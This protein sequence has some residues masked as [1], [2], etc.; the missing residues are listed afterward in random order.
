MQGLYHTVIHIFNTCMMYISCHS[1]TVLTSND[2]HVS[3]KLEPL[4]CSTVTKLFVW[5]TSSM[6]TH[7]L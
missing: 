3:D 7:D 1:V 2:S 5:I 6:Y 4:N